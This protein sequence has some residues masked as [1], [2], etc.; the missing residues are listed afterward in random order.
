M[1]SFICQVQF[2]PNFDLQYKILRTF[3]Q[4]FHASTSASAEFKHFLAWKDSPFIIRYISQKWNLETTFPYKLTTFKLNIDFHVKLI[5]SFVVPA[6]SHPACQ[7][8]DKRCPE[9]TSAI[10]CLIRL[11]MC[12]LHAHD[13]LQEGAVPPGVGDLR[14]L[15]VKV[16]V[17]QA[18]RHGVLSGGG[19]VRQYF[20]VYKYYGAICS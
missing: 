20:P 16:P 19:G 2:S 4:L 13:R 5:L 6:G 8:K 11:R 9:K 12:F 7:Q 1:S 18:R 10:C 14:W 17:R 3:L 15:E